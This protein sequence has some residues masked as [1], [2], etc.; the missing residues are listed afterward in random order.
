MGVIKDTSDILSS[1]INSVRLQ[2]SIALAAY[3]IIIIQL[4][5][6]S[7]A[8]IIEFR[9]NY[10]G[11]ILSIALITTGSLVFL[12]LQRL[13]V[14]LK[15]SKFLSSYSR[16]RKVKQIER[17]LLRRVIP[18]IKTLH[19][20]EHK[21]LKDMLNLKHHEIRI[22]RESDQLI[23]CQNLFKKGIL[24]PLDSY[25]H[26]SGEFEFYQRYKL[27]ETIE[28]FLRILYL[29][30]SKEEMVF[31]EKETEI[32]FRLIMMHKELDYILNKLKE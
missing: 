21:I 28:Q 5:F 24:I 3:G 20:E 30:L 29:E 12:G 17:I 11:W 16:K 10:Y 6:E 32:P 26:Y 8:S 27:D 4:Y 18:A 2:F 25:R 15:E 1:V 14:S 23:H 7:L 22:H 9:D 13:N 31:Q 19:S